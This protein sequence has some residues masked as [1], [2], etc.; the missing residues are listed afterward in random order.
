MFGG[1]RKPYSAVTVQ[2]DRLTSEQYEEEDFGGLIDLVEVIRIQASGPTEAARALRKK[3]KYGTTHRQIR[4][5][6]ILDGLMENGDSRFQRAFLDEPLLERL[7]IMA[8]EDMVDPSVKKKCQ[9]LFIQ[10][11]NAYKNTPGLER[12]ANLYKELPRSQRPMA[13]RQKVVQDDHADSEPEARHSPSPAPTLSGSRSRATSSAQ[14]PLVASAKNQPVT[15]APASSAL[16]SKH[17]KSKSKYSYG[18]PF[19]L[20]KEKDNMTNCIARASIASTN[21]LNGLQLAN[22]ETERVSQNREIVSRFETA[23]S[24]RRQILLYIQQVESDDW[25]GSLVNANDELVK[26]LTAYEIMDR[27]IEDDSDSEWEQPPPEAQARPTQGSHSRHVS[28]DTAAQLAG[29]SLAEENPPSKPARPAPASVPMPPPPS[30]P[31]RSSRHDDAGEEDDDDDDPFGDSNAAPTPHQERPVDPSTLDLQCALA[32][33]GSQLEFEDRIVSWQ[34]DTAY[35]GH[36]S[37][38]ASSIPNSDHDLRHSRSSPALFSLSHA[39]RS[40][41][42]LDRESESRPLT[43]R[44]LA[45][46]QGITLAEPDETPAS[47][48]GSSGLLKRLGRILNNYVTQPSKSIPLQHLPVRQATHATSLSELREIEVGQSASNAASP[49]PRQMPIA[50]GS[51]T[52]QEGSAPNSSQ[53]SVVNIPRSSTSLDEAP[54]ARE[55]LLDTNTSSQSNTGAPQLELSNLGDFTIRFSLEAQDGHESN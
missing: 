6:V 50:G 30:F 19:N 18:K 53:N 10:W 14:P 2:I 52:A 25:I 54:S 24:L 29:L 34:R 55:P 35:D 44:N 46:G 8:R 41:S 38:P 4:A 23:K 7:R 40:P 32:R 36:G 51:S 33:S 1:P 12:I 31:E 45:L 9:V 20:A 26:A 39:L 11:A 17:S 37:A 28:A 43:A 5:L 3:L 16:P 13:A 42:S 27:S 48:R 21:L 47:R 22:R 49:S 15:L